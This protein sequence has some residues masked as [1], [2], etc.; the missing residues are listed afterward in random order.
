V[1]KGLESVT[2]DKREEFVNSLISGHIKDFST[3][4]E[5][6]NTSEG[7]T[8]TK[9]VLTQI[10]FKDIESQSTYQAL[11][12]DWINKRKAIDSKY[13][14]T[15]I[16][17][18]YFEQNSGCTICLPTQISPNKVTEEMR[19]Q[20]IFDN[21]QKI[22]AKGL[23]IIL[24]GPSPAEIILNKAKNNPSEFNITSKVEPITEIKETNN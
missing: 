23:A 10:T 15:P 22:G 1:G 3:T 2:G 20:R 6:L 8:I 5:H 19:N 18:P 4:E 21:S 16:G 7:H 11:E 13:T 24:L 17:A 12:D 9:P 14:I